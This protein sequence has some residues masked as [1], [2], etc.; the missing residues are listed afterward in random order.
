MPSLPTAAARFSADPLFLAVVREQS[1][2]GPD[3]GFPDGPNTLAARRRPPVK[4][5][6]HSWIVGRF[7]PLDRRSNTQLVNAA[8]DQ[9]C[10]RRRPGSSTA[11]ASSFAPIARAPASPRTGISLKWNRRRR[12]PHH[13]AASSRCA[14]PSRSSRHRAAEAKIRRAGFFG[15]R[16]PRRRQVPAAIDPIARRRRRRSRTPA[17]PATTP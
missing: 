8:F 5:V 2:A 15:T 9:G 12:R 10:W 14:G 4:I 16:P 7:D 1:N 11:A 3:Q 6:A 17:A 13:R